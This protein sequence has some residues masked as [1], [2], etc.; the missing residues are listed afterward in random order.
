MTDDPEVRREL[1]AAFGESSYTKEG[2]LNRSYLAQQVFGHADRVARINGIV[3]PR[4]AEAFREMKRRAKTDGIRLLVHEAALI[5]ESGAHRR[6]DA[7]AVV[8]SP[9]ADRIRRVMARD[10]VSAGQV[11][12]RMKHQLPAEEL[13]QRADYVIDNAGSLEELRRKVTVLYKKLISGE[14]T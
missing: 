8:H 6:L 3:H 5:F 2:A 7:V 4:V 1:V 14:E 10:S 13:I 11:E 9:A 12:S